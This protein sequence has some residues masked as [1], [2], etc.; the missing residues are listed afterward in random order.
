MH[1]AVHIQSGKHGGQSLKAASD[2]TT[3]R[4]LFVVDR[5]TKEHYLVDT[6][7]DVSVYPYS[8][9]RRAIKKEI[10][11]LYAANG[12]TIA[13]YGHLNLQ[14]DFGLRRAFPWRFIIAE[15]TQPIIGSDFL[16]YYH[17]LPDLQKGKLLD[18]NTGLA[19]KA[20]TKIHEMKSVKTIH[21]QTRFHEILNKYPESHN[22]TIVIIQASMT[23]NTIKELHQDH[24]RHANREDW[25]RTN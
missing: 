25:H 11:E 2:N 18:G 3:S 13:T 5:N 7:S 12:S 22:Q 6:G 4:R 14:P 24:R 17:L 20:E 10:Y 9:I 19:T 16:S 21:G 23:R 1:Q 8:R 15:V